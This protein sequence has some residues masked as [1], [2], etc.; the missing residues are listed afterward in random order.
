MRDKE[1]EKAMAV[2]CKAAG[3]RRA[4][5]IRGMEA[6][7]THLRTEVEVFEAQCSDLPEVSHHLSKATSQLKKAHVHLMTEV[8]DL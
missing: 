1:Y 7:L 6:I 4:D 3:N 8:E 2:A 5:A